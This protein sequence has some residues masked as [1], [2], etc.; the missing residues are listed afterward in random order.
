M[1]ASSID[2]TYFAPIAA[3]MAAAYIILVGEP[4]KA[5]RHYWWP[6]IG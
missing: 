3:A 2:S 4:K 6:Y 1:I 5:Q